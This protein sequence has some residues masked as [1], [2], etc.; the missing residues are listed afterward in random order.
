MFL[1]MGGEPTRLWHGVI[2]EKQ[3]EI[4]RGS[5]NSPVAGP[6]RPRIRLMNRPETG[7][8]DLSFE[9][10]PGPIRRAVVNHYDLQIGARLSNLTSNR[11]DDGLQLL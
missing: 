10:I 7:D 2:A 11:S 3:D 1:E 5:L 6:R 4:A 9:P 8:L